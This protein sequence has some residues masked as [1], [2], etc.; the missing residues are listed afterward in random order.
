MEL[1]HKIQSAALHMRELAKDTKLPGY[2]EKMLHAAEELEQRANER[3]QWRIARTI[4]AT[5]V[6]VRIPIR[7]PLDQLEPPT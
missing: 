7:R 6:R 5:S 3:P 2:A 4:A 1:V